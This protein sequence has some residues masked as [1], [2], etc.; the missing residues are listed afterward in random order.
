MGPLLPGGLALCCGWRHPFCPLAGPVGDSAP[1]PV[2]PGGA[3]H[4][5][6][7]HRAGTIGSDIGA[8]CSPACS[9]GDANPGLPWL[10][11]LQ[12]CGASGLFG[13]WCSVTP[14][15]YAKLSLQTHVQGVI[16]SHCNLR[17]NT[18]PCHKTF[19]HQL[20]MLRK[21]CRQQAPACK[22]RNTG[23][24]R[25]CRHI[26]PVQHVVV[27]ALC[28]LPLLRAGHDTPDKNRRAR[29]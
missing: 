4:T 9:L 10:P 1:L 6:S 21:L 5:H 16:G 2:A 17:G 24:G 12:Q 20:I 22:A 14:D 7:A 26:A 29:A 28:I 3:T 27:L 19:H 13:D 15:P 11:W 25:T 23:A 18:E 8:V